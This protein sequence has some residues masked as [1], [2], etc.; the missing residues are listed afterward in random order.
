MKALRQATIGNRLIIEYNNHGYLIV[1]SFPIEDGNI[2]PL[3]RHTHSDSFEGVCKRFLGKEPSNTGEC[4][5]GGIARQYSRI[6][7]RYMCASCHD[8]LVKECV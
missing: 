4:A 3:H 5:C 7:E 6:K 8:V 2:N 1:E